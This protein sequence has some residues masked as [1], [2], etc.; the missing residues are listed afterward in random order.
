MKNLMMAT[1]AFTLFATVT[2]A[3]DTPGIFGY[4]GGQKH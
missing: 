1:L 2:R 4:P 3:Q